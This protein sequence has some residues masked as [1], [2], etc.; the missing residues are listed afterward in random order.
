VLVKHIHYLSRP[1]QLS[2]MP[3]AARAIRRLR[4]AE[5]K[6]ILVTNQS[7]VGR[8]YFSL[9]QL[10]KIHRRLR[11]MLTRGNAKL[12]AIYYCPHAPASKSRA[13]SCRKPAAALFKR[14]A[15]RFAIDLKSSFV[16]GDSTSD[17][18]A[19]RNIGAT[20]ILVKT[21]YGGSDGRHRVEADKTCRDLA[22]AARWIVCF[23]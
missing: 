22:S 10:H 20:A 7:G 21:G 2:L 16:V 11:E 9:R 23:P 4:A 13:C 17:I 19:A 5:F 14:A 18:Q 15:K 12:D 1:E 8:G 6:V 3:G